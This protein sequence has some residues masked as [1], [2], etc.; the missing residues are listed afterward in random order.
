MP[1]VGAH[2][3]PYHATRHGHP[4][5]SRAKSAGRRHRAARVHEADEARLQLA[6]GRAALRVLRFR[7][8]NI[9]PPRPAWRHVIDGDSDPLGATS[10]LEHDSVGTGL[11]AAPEAPDGE[12]R[13]ERVEW[14]LGPDD[15]LSSLNQ[16][17]A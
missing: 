8:G 6:N 13:D 11:V 9:P 14:P 16:V 4:R 12:G 7:T 17:P 5:R 3:A 2:Y 1:S 10:G 15:R